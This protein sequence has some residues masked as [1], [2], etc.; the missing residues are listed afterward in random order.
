MAFV[1]CVSAL[2]ISSAHAQSD[3]SSELLPSVALRT[4]SIVPRVSL[5]GTLTDN[6]FLSDANKRSEQTTEISPGIR[7]SADGS[8]VKAY[9]DYSRRET[10]YAQNTSVRTSQNALNTFGSVEAIDNWAFLDFSGTVSQQA[11]RSKPVLPS[12]RRAPAQ[13]FS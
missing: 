13:V 12:C 1:A 4:I 5:T 7:V 2:S 8:R 6:V 11:V 10:L 3:D 9:F